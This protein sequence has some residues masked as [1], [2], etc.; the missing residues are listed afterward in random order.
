MVI[1]ILKTACPN[2]LP[3][4]SYK[5]TL[6]VRNIYGEYYVKASYNSMFK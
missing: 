6:S 3:Y 5:C 1:Y 4:S 2:L